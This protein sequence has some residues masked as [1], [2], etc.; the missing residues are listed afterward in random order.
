MAMCLFAVHMTFLLFIDADIE[1][2]AFRLP[3][4]FD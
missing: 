4:R 1:I 3:D 2:A